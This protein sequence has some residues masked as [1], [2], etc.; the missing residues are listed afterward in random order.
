MFTHYE[1]YEEYILLLVGHFDE[2]PAEFGWGYHP[3][4]QLLHSQLLSTMDVKLFVLDNAN[5]PVVKMTIV[6]GCEAFCD[7]VLFCVLMT[8]TVLNANPPLLQPHVTYVAFVQL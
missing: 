7:A 5:I 4:K 2:E 8:I 6:R 3:V 1:L